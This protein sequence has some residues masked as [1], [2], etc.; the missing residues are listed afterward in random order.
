MEVSRLTS[1]KTAQAVQRLIALINTKGKSGHHR[2]PTIKKLSSELKASPV[3]IFKA[4]RILRDRGLLTAG[5]RKGIWVS[6]G[7]AKT[8]PRDPGLQLKSDPKVMKWEIIKNRI[9]D[10]LLKGQ[11]PPGA[12]LP[13]CKELTQR[14]GACFVILKHALVSMEKEG[15]ISRYKKGF[16][17]FQTA[18]RRFRPL[19]A[20][21]ASMEKPDEFVGFDRNSREFWR[22]LEW[23]CQRLEMDLEIFTFNDLLGS[24][25]RD[26]ERQRR[27]RSREQTGIVAGYCVWNLNATSEQVDFLYVKLAQTGRRVAFFFDDESAPVPAGIA[28]NRRFKLFAKSA[29]AAAGKMVAD[30]LTGLGHRRIA[31]FSSVA[32]IGWSKAR[33]SGI[34]HACNS[35]GLPPVAEFSTDIDDKIKALWD[36][37]PDS[38]PFASLQPR[39]I[40]I[41]RCM[42]PDVK[43]DDRSYYDFSSDLFI[44]SLVDNA[45]R[46]LFEKA[47]QDTGIT[48][49]IGV[50]DDIALSALKFLQEKDVRLPQNLSLIGFDNTM[51]GLG[52]GLTSYSFNISA[53]AIA[54][55]D[56]LLGGRMTR[57]ITMQKPIQIPGVV[58][59]RRTTGP[60]PKKIDK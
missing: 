20:V 60:A 43:A 56:H 42:N 46:P 3:T 36:H 1:P 6:P 11:Y 29:G 9:V 34:I 35:A 37:A 32:G 8:I 58:L 49:W 17:V 15:R 59:E 25:K 27:L 54:M 16:R 10:D 4:V 23:E 51:Q 2:I 18:Q 45:M 22:T 31:C 38:R 52:A 41:Q 39:L 55:L 44:R 47:L 40:E 30:F 24:E 48:A 7:S 57:G 26:I 33:V 12:M 5:P 13:S 14:Y 19:L 50:N 21:V 28:A 53:I